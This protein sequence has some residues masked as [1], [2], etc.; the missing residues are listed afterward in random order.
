M[1]TS[2]TDK[3]TNVVCSVWPS[4]VNYETKGKQCVVLLGMPYRQF[5]MIRDK[6]KGRN[7]E[8]HRHKECI[9]IKY[10]S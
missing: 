7:N 9:A 5:V 8:V 6:G 3:I 4:I 10:D 1:H 2:A